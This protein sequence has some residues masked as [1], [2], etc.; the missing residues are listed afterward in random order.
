M[1]SRE[2]W[3]ILGGFDERFTPGYFE[4]FDLGWKANDKGW[5]T[6]WIPSLTVSHTH[7]ESTFKKNFSSK[8]LQRIKDRNYLLSHWNNLK[9]EQYPDHFLHLLIRCLKSPGYTVPLFMAIW[10]KCIK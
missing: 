9:F 7:P 8:F 2:K 1:I 5:K 3:D 10:K 6:L 4:D